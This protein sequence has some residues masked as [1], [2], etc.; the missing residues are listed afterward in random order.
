MDSFATAFSVS[1]FIPLHKIY[2]YMSGNE[3]CTVGIINILGNILLFVPM[4]IFLPALF[5]KMDD[6]KRVVVTAS[7]ISFLVEFIQ[8]LT[9]TGE[10][11]V[12]DILL[13]SIGGAIGYVMADKSKRVGLLNLS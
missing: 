1:N 10:F 4:G 5:D 7:C 2:Y 13:N 8:L 6:F 11:D 12:D 3:P 9:Q